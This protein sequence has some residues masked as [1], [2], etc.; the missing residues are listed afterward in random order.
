MRNLLF[1]LIVT[2][3]WFLSSSI[4]KAQEM[5]DFAV[6]DYFP[7][8]RTME[9]S[10]TGHQFKAFRFS[11]EDLQ[12]END[13]DPVFREIR[14]ME[15]EGWELINTETGKTGKAC[16]LGSHTFFLKRKK[17]TL[18]TADTILVYKGKS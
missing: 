9:L 6:I 18:E 4:A 5:H 17:E 3:I 10:M 15:E 1:T 7:K 14:K 8:T 16:A 11:D 13:M 12:G 2:I